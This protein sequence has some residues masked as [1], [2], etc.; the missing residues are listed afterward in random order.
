[1]TVYHVSGYQVSTERVGAVSGKMEY[2]HTQ[3]IQ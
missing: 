1:M 3:V 2:D